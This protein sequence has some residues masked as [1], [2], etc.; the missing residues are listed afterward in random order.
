MTFIP[1]ARI[2][3]RAAELWVRHRLEPG[4]DVE[5]LVDD[6][7]LGLVWESIPDGGEGR[8]LGQ[9][10]PDDRLIALNENHLELLDQN[11]G[12]LRRFTVGH[13]IGHWLLH[14]DDVRSGTIPL[15]DGKRIWCRDGSKMAIERQAEMFSAALL[16]PRD[17]VLAALPDA[18]WSGWSP[19]YQLAETFV[20]NATPM[21]IRL[22]K[23]GCAHRDEH[24]TP[25]C[26]RAD[27]PGQGSLFDAVTEGS[28][29]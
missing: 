17:R 9:L 4:F 18:P 22:E 20:V 23:F 10:I 11:N 19:V 26:G 3:A 8:V 25:V 28:N 16:M 29:G 12:R 27:P 1:E 24:G 6:L 5:Q 15:F 2:E 21:I 14:A 13:E 7:G